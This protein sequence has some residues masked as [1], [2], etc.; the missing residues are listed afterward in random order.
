MDIKTA[1]FM[2]TSG[3]SRDRGKVVTIPRDPSVRYTST[4]F[5]LVSFDMDTIDLAEID[6]HS[7]RLK[8]DK[9]MLKYPDVDKTRTVEDGTEEPYIEYGYFSENG[10]SSFENPPTITIKDITW[11]AINGR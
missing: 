5:I 10:T 7:V 9:L 4:N 6:T 3:L 8:L 11:E 1:P 2:R